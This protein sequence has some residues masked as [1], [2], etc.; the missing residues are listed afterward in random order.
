MVCPHLFQTL[1]ELTLDSFWKSETVKIIVGKDKQTFFIHQNLLAASKFFQ[2]CI[3]SGFEEATTKTVTLEED[4]PDAVEAFIKW[5]YLGKIEFNNPPH[6]DLVPLFTF[7]DK[8]CCEVYCNDLIDAIRKFDREK[9]YFWKVLSSKKVYQAGLRGTAL[10]RYAVKS[11]VHQLQKYPKNLAEK[12]DID[13]VE[14]FEDREFMQDVIKEVIEYQQQPY[15]EPYSFN[16]C[17]FHSHVEGSVCSAA[18]GAKQ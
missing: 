3:N 7:A 16:G 10:A 9:N 14:A 8:I 6:A 12:A 4:E 1:H 15:N 13:N 2:A 5:L 17:I 18:N 11:T